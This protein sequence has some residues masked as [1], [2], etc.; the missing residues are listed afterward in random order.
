[1]CV[2]HI[3]RRVCGPGL[4][5]LTIFDVLGKAAFIFTCYSYSSICVSTGVL[6]LHVLSPITAVI[7]GVCVADRQRTS[8]RTTV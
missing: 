4:I 8:L 2:G 1:M 5:R 7:H 6:L 3:C